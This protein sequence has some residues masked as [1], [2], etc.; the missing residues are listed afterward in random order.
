MPAGQT[1][2]L[3]YFTIVSPTRAEAIAAANAL[4]TPAGF[5]GQAAAFLSSADLAA[6]GN[7][8]FPPVA[9]TVSLNTHSPQTNDVLTAT[10]TKSDADGNR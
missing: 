7:F 10:A 8:Q 6:L 5:G 2:R 3:A 4:V 1:V 9:A